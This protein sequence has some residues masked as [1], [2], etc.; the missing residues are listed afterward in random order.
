MCA[1]RYL[2]QVVARLVLLSPSAIPA[3][4]ASSHLPPD[5]LDA[6]NG[7]AKEVSGASPKRDA[8]P[9]SLP[10][11]EG[12]ADSAEKQ[13]V[14]EVTVTGSHIRGAAPIGSQLI[15]LTHEELSNAGLSTIE[16]ILR[17]LPQNFGGG[18]S[19]DT[20]IGTEAITN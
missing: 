6:R 16:Q 12:D 11:S 7:H 4:D 13:A 3:H 20:S 1:N 8:H 15:T 19:E 9:Q 17:T 14:G 18:P 2:L 5:L 10:Q